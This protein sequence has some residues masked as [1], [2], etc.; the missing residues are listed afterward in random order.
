[1]KKFHSLFANAPSGTV[2]YNGNGEKVENLGV[3]EHWNNS[4]EKNT[5]ETEAKTK[6]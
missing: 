4:L 5:V 6:E 2:Y 1:M 3:H